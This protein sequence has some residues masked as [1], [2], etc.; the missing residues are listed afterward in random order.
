[1]LAAVDSSRWIDHLEASVKKEPSHLRLYM[2]KRT[3]GLILIVDGQKR[4]LG[5]RIVPSDSVLEHE[6]ALREWL[7][8]GAH[9]TAHGWIFPPVKL[10]FAR[11]IHTET[12]E[13]KAPRRSRRRPLWL[14]PA[15]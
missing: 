7:E 5:A 15:L 12:I 3:H 4:I 11:V 8:R 6:Y 2:P 13:L 10:P 1:M 9:P 14:E